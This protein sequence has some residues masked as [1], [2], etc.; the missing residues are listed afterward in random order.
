MILKLFILSVFLLLP[1]LCLGESVQKPEKVYSE[2]EFEKAVLDEV[3]KRLDKIQVSNLANFSNDLLKKESNLNKREKT[4]KEK[5]RQLDIATKEFTSKIKKFQKK[6]KKFLGCIN[7]NERQKGKRVSR[8]VEIIAGMKAKK[9]AELLSIQEV[10]LA[11][12]ILEG[13]K[14]DKSAKIFNLMDREISARL[15]KKYLIMKQ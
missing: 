5:N 7:E 10:D 13:L 12:Q 3:S 11:V 6:Q 4:L 15:Q 8:L 1:F 2:D 9:A 14:P